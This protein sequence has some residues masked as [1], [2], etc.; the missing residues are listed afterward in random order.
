MAHAQSIEPRVY[1]P[2][3]VGVNFLLVAYADSRGGLSFDDASP[4][5]NPQLH[6]QGPIFAYA[7]S[8]GLAGQLAKLDV[9]LPTGRLSGSADYLGQRVEREVRGAGDPLA[10]LSVSLYGTPA[11][12]TAAFRSYRQDLIIGASLQVSAPL[13]QYDPD[14]LL[15]LGTNRWSFH[16][17]VGLSQAFGPWMA[18]FAAG[19]TFY[20]TNDN[21]FG[22]H[23]RSQEPL[24]SGR[25][26]LIYNFRAGQWISLDSTFYTGGQT[27]LDGQR[28]NNLQRNSRLGTTLAVP[29]NRRVSVKFNASRGVSARTGNNYDLVGVALQY[30]WGG[31]L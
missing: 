3:P 24:Y 1:S 21:F 17:E 28:E 6:V 8:F 5:E 15:N 27:T 22:G 16:P 30:R 23:R 13:G 11:L 2:A 10:R 26:N 9:I 18:E 31:G 14:R 19:A 12:D 7:R 4:L 20:T 29:V 25:A